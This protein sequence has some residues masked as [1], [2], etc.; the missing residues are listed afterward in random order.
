MCEVDDETAARPL[1]TH[2]K[3]C[4]SAL[5]ECCWT[6]NIHISGT[7]VYASAPPFLTWRE[8]ERNAARLTVMDLKLAFIFLG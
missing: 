2:Q 6:H 7:G 5:C 4:Q 3:K 1:Q 8:V